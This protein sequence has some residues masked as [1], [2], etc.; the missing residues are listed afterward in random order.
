M[1]CLMSNVHCPTVEQW[2]TEVLSSAQEWARRRFFALQQ[3]G[4]QNILAINHRN[5]KKNKN[6][7]CALPV[8]LPQGLRCYCIVPNLDGGRNGK[9]G[10]KPRP[11]HSA[12][13]LGLL[14]QIC[15]IGANQSPRST[16]RPRTS[17]A[18]FYQLWDST[19]GLQESRRDNHAFKLHL[20]I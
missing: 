15:T 13:W 17:P 4:D 8:V 19:D 2:I 9:M 18:A 1:T 14:T 11:Q 5:A 6:Q 12:S 10:Q 3:P 16:E 20:H 7:S